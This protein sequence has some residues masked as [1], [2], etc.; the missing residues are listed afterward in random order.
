MRR[1]LLGLCALGM[2]CAACAPPGWRALQAWGAIDAARIPQATCYGAHRVGA[3]LR[4]GP[5]WMFSADVDWVA[6]YHGSSPYA[7]SVA[8]LADGRYGVPYATQG[9]GSDT[10]SWGASWLL[11]SAPLSWGVTDETEAQ[12]WVDQVIAWARS[13]PH[14]V[15]V[16]ASSVDVVVFSE[17]ALYMYEIDRAILGASSAVWDV[18]GLVE[19]GTP[20]SRNAVWDTQS[21]YAPPLSSSRPQRVLCLSASAAGSAQLPESE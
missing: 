13:T 18:T 10:G 20:P 12:R 2:A 15:D 5:S 11:E 14:V 4:P 17:G 21:E 7:P 8:V 9:S 1:V 19:S 16:D 6:L 3:I